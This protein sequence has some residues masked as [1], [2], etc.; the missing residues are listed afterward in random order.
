MDT[1][2]VD[3]LPEQRPTEPTRGPRWP[4]FL[5]AGFLA[6]GLV[7]LLLWPVKVPY[8]ALSPGPVEQV[9]DL[10]TIDGAETYP[11]TGD[12]YLLT[13]S[14]RDV[15]V[16]EYIEA[17]FDDEV[18]LYDREVIR[19]RGVSRE[20]QKRTNLELMDGSI[21]AALF[22]ALGRLGY[23]VGF[24]GDGVVVL[25]V[26]EDSP[27]DGVLQEGDIV[28]AVAGTAVE[29]TDQ[30]AEIIRSF[31]VGDTITLSIVR[32]DQPMD[33]Q[34]TLVPHPDIE[35]APMVGVQLD[36]I[37]LSLSIPI[38]VDVDSRNIGGPSAGMIYAVSLIDLLTPEDLTKG[39]R[40][41]GTGTIS[42]D[43]TVGSIGGVR[44]KVFAARAIGVEIV[45][46]P[47][48]NYQDAL[49]ASGDGIRIVPVTT[50]QEVLDFLDAL[51]PA[52]EAVAGP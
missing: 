12:L 48:A 27:S 38:D 41:A 42:F 26:V 24:E 5:V 30:A 21:E 47:E 46:V 23:D 4:Y 29:V 14:P 1:G 8:V 15:N 20:E 17:Q 2:I 39:H 10:I 16:F 19:P 50:L 43:E 49:T 36:T 44:Q 32:D 18:D 31:D 40:I 35:G 52:P 37:N 3:T 25:D 51:E 7:V 34:I 9:P 13:V 11:P 6:L 45:F 28:A 33:V 22:V